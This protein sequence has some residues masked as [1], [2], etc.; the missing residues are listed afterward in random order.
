M[1]EKTILALNLKIL[2]EKKN[3]SSDEV[4]EALNLKSATYR[5]YEIDTMPKVLTCLDLAKYFGVTV[6][7]LF[8][9]EDE[10]SEKIESLNDEDI[11]D[12]DFSN[13][14]KA[15]KIVVK[16]LRTISDSDFI[17]VINYVNSKKDV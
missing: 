9:E 6:E 15:E 4:A 10:F 3:V 17:D 8:K 16:K 13:L 7:D 1:K 11:K 12:E 2:R 14:N 5:R